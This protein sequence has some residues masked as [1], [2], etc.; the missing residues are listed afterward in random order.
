M[1][2]HHP[3][4]NDSQPGVFGHLPITAGLVALGLVLVFS[5]A[6]WQVPGMRDVIVFAAAAAA[7]AGT[8]V[9]T[10]YS[11]VAVRQTSRLHAEAAQVARLAAERAQKAEEVASDRA[12]VAASL[13]LIERFNDPMFSGTLTR[14]REQRGQILA[15]SPAD[16][17]RRLEADLASRAVVQEILNRLEEIAIIVLSG[18]ADEKTLRDSLEP[19]VHD[20]YN[21]C[22]SWVEENRRQGDPLAWIKIDELHQ[23]WLR[24]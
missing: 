20:V 23:K 4:R 16:T 6:Y 12:K 14:W 15:A 9:S 19:I 8:V 13:R 1:S 7:A 2:N 3:E 10:F 17:S 11:S 5:V 22:E 18:V 21:V 24:R